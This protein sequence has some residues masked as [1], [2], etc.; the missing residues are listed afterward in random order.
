M[1]DIDTDVLISDTG[2]TNLAI[3]DATN[4]VELML[5]AYSGGGLIGT[6]TNHDLT[7]RTNNANVMTLLTSGFVGI[8]TTAPNSKLEVQGSFNMTDD[9][10]KVYNNATCVIIEG[11]TSVLTIC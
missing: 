3:R 11:A 6:M 10:R 8:G 7:F 4:D 9:T 1:L 2:T 5:Y